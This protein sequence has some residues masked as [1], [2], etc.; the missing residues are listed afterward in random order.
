MRDRLIRVLAVPALLTSL[1]CR[2]DWTVTGLPS[3]AGVR[4][5]FFVQESFAT[6]QL[7][8]PTAASLVVLLRAGERTDL[9]VAD[10]FFERPAPPGGCDLVDVLNNPLRVTWR[11]TDPAVA[12]PS[13]DGRTAI[14]QLVA[15][16]PGKARIFADVTVGGETQRAE[17]HYYCCGGSCP[18][19]PPTCRRV[20]VD[21]VIVVP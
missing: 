17:L 9:F 16:G 11:T 14:G 6:T 2:S 10:T 21:R 13:G 7:E 18:P 15:V 12:V 3:C 4:G 20:P 5:P 19:Q 8:D 1:A